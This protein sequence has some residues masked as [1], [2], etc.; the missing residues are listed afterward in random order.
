MTLIKNVKTTSYVDTTAKSGTAYIYTVRARNGSTLSSYY[1]NGINILF[2]G[3]PDV[4]S[5]A[6]A[7]NGV[8]VK[9]AKVSGAK[10]YRVYRKTGNGPA[11]CRQA[12]RQGETRHQLHGR[13]SAAFRYDRTF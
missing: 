10:V 1:A 11:S 9:W 4:K 7:T 13:G 12:K 6:A 3:T 2:L 8:T 5:A